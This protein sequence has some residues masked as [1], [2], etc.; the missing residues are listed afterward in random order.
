MEFSGLIMHQFFQLTRTISQTLNELLSPYNLHFS[1]W[2]VILTLMEKGAMT[3][4]Q[5]ANY[6]KV[7]PSA[8][9]RTLVRLKKKGY[10]EKKI[11]ADHRERQVALTEFAQKQYQQ[12]ENIARQHREG[13]LIDFSEEEK[14]SIYNILEMIIQRA[15]QH[16]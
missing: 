11:G 3:Q 12:W 7:E 13:L 1:E 6:L 16:K 2:G 4:G 14:K 9:S 10:I 8:I 5:L 15:S